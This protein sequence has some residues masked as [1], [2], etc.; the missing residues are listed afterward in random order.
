ML[1][2]CVPSESGIGARGAATMRQLGTGHDDDELAASTQN[3]CVKRTWTLSKRHHRGVL[4]PTQLR[5]REEP[6]DLPLELS[7]NW[8]P[9]S[10]H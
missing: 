6:V 5:Q 1:F 7:K 8:R 4:D 2:V 9:Y 3:T 10:D